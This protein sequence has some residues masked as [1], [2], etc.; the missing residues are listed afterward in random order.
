[1]NLTA[2]NLAR[3]I[4]ED[5]TFEQGPCLYP[6]GFKPP[7]KGHYEVVKD[8]AS[9]SYISEV[10]IVISTKDRDGINAKQSLETWKTY[11]ECAPIPKAQVSISPYPS[12]VTYV[13]KFIE[14]RA[15]V[16]PIYVA[17]GADEVD[18]QN[19]FDSLQ[20]RFGDQVLSIAIPEKFGRISATTMREAL[21]TGNYEKFKECVPEAVNQ[22]GQSKRLFKS[23]ADTIREGVV[24]PETEPKK[25]ALPDAYCEENRLKQIL[26]NQGLTLQK[27]SAK[28]KASQ[29]RDFLTFSYDLLEVEE[30]PEIE[31]I[32]DPSFARQNFTFGSYNPYD[33][34]ISVYINNRNCADILR[35]LAHELIHHR[36]NELGMLQVGAGDT[37][38]DIENEANATAGIILREYGRRNPTI[39]E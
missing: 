11:L 5:V 10:H 33:Y 4:V 20:K 7:H 15:D 35:T 26:E 6:G 18:T 19:Y 24:R 22:K 14:A 21:R 27:A 2:I 30:V 31:I 17:G 12:P 3:T 13:Y 38:S 32:T 23:L 39:Y 34:K 36:Q 37:G 8:L 1:M 28:D 16:K 25:V 29:I 9:R